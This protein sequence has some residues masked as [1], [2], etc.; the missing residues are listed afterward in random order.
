MSIFPGHIN[1]IFVL[2]KLDETCW[3]R[4]KLI[5]SKIIDLSYSCL[6]LSVISPDWLNLQFWSDLL[7]IRKYQGHAKTFS[8]VRIWQ[9]RIIQFGVACPQ[10]TKRFPVDLTA[11]SV[12]Q[13]K[14]TP[15]SLI[16]TWSYLLMTIASILSRMSLQLSHI[17]LIALACLNPY[18]WPCPR[19]IQFRFSSNV[20]KLVYISETIHFGV[21]RTWSMKKVPIDQN[22]DNIATY[23]FC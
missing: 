12:V 1:F 20:I 9:C 3:Y 19:Q 7:Q 13:I 6:H 14:A 18:I 10:A 11:G 23:V 4:R 17:E 2:T 15:F 8:W 21:F 5:T 16:K 22:G